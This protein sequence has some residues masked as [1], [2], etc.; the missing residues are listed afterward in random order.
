M[1]A[2]PSTSPETKL[3]ARYVRAPRLLELLFDEG[4]RPSLRTLRSWQ[5]QRRV[6]FVRIGRGIYFDPM[7]CKAALDSTAT[8]KARR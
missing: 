6:P 5:R 1:N 4:D 7:A 8:I 2:T 3:P